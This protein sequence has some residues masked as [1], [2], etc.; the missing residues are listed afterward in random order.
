MTHHGWAGDYADAPFAENAAVHVWGQDESR[1]VTVGIDSSASPVEVEVAADWTQRLAPTQLPGAVMGAYRSAVRHLLT[2]EAA[3]RAEMGSEGS[4]RGEAHPLAE[5]AVRVS[6]ALSSDEIRAHIAEMDEAFGSTLRALR[7]ARAR[8]R[9]M[10]SATYSGSAV[11]GAV[12]VE[13]SAS[14][15]LTRVE[16]DQPWLTTPFASDVG[17]HVT[18]AIGRARAELQRMRP[19]ALAPL[20]GIPQGN[21]TI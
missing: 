13:L 17:H 7:Q 15:H 21:R 4:G 2:E 11:R 16:L 6:S 8:V 18:V 14:G 12:V 10:R 5:G 9:G 3:D 19:D 1:A 20:R